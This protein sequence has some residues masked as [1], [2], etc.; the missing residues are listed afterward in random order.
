MAV[1]IPFRIQGASQDGHPDRGV[2]KVLKPGIEDRLARELGLLQDVG[3]FLDERCAAFGIPPLDYREVFDQVREK[4]G[5]EVN[6]E[7]SSAI[8]ARPRRPMPASPRS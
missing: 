7:E 8:F 5:T 3:G 1:V 2:F 4:L 6:L